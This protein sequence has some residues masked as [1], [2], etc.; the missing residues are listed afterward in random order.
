MSLSSTIFKMSMQLK[1]LP[2]ELLGSRQCLYIAGDLHPN[3]QR[4]DF[5]NHNLGDDLNIPLIEALSGKHVIPFRYSLFGKRRPRY[6]VIGSI[7]EEW[8]SAHAIVWGAGLMHPLSK[9][10]PAPKAIYAVRGP[11]TR[12]EL[13]KQGMACP[14]IYGDP[15]ILLPHVYTPPPADKQGLALIPHVRDQEHPFVSK[16]RQCGGKVLDL[17]Q[18]GDWRQFIRELT[19]CKG[20]LSSSLHGLILSDAYGI[21]SRRLVL[22]REVTGGDFKYLDYYMSFLS[23]P[24]SPLCPEDIENMEPVALLDEITKSWHVLPREMSGAL[25]DCCPFLKNNFLT[26]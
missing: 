22:G 19:S 21:P 13:L 6:L 5:S 24:P 11:L 23:S 9:E 14:E 18:Y 4:H 15:A 8:C 3:R 2:W 1:A 12:N 26:R 20:V 16:W 25:L 17:R 7:L 10:I